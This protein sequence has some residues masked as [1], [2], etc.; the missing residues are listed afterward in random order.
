MNSTDDNSQLDLRDVRRRFDRAASGFDAID[1]VHSATR[2]GLLTRL[3]PMLIDA[4]TIVDL[5][6]ATG[7][8]SRTLS[9]Q[10]RRAHIISIDLS[11]QMLRQA[12]RKRSLFGRRSLLQ[13]NAAALP[14]AGHSVDLIFANLL[15]P[16][17]SDPTAV[18]SEVSRV[19]RKDGLFI[20]STLGPDSLRELHRAWQ[21]AGDGAHVNRF[22]DMHDIGDIAVRSGLRDPVL[23]VDH[24]RVSYEKPQALFDDLTAM[25]GR[26]SLQ[27]RRRSLTGKIRFKAMTAALAAAGPLTLDLELVYGHC[28]GSGAAPASGEVRIDAIQ[29]GRRSR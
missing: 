5:G 13:A 4:K 14:L 7:A 1:F 26:N 28:W 20:F 18:F 21:S 27:N 6:C 2:E 9:K 10:F 12:Q 25:G 29:I 23:D 22:L 19:L 3:A 16:W 11:Q 15:L 8:A 24:L 17:I